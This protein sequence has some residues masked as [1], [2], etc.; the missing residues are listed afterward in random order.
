MQRENIANKGDCKKVMVIL[1][2]LLGLSSIAMLLYLPNG[3]T[4]ITNILMI[5]LVI[6]FMNVILLFYLGNAPSISI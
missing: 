5:I 2:E 1:W 4:I 6:F 3:N